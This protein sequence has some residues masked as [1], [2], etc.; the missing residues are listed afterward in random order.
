MS[1]E[2]LGALNE[3]KEKKKRNYVSFCRL[4]IVSTQ[5]LMA[6]K[7]RRRKGR[8]FFFFFLNSA[9]ESQQKLACVAKWSALQ[10]VAHQ[11]M[12]LNPI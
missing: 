2:P 1:S 5:I 8:I 6:K 12:V 9:V 11:V 3:E 10:K 4:T 7:K